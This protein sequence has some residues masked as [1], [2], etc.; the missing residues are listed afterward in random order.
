MKV[1]YKLGFIFVLFIALF[2]SSFAATYNQN[3]DLT[4]DIDSLKG[5]VFNDDIVQTFELEVSNNLNSKQSIQILKPTIEGWDI[6][7]SEENLVLDSNE[8]QIISLKI[9]ANANFDYGKSVVSPDLLKIIQ[10]DNYEGNTNFLFTIL[11][12]NENVSFNYNLVVE[13]KNTAEEYKIEIAT[14]KISPKQP[15]KFS[16]KGENVASAQTIQVVLKYADKEE[17]F[18]DTF[19]A[20]EHYKIY[21]QT[22]ENTIS[23][24]PILVEITIRLKKENGLVWEWI[25]E[26]DII[27][28]EYTQLDIEETSKKGFFKNTYTTT[29]TNLGNIDQEYQ[30]SINVN[31]FNYLFFTSNLEEER[32]DGKAQINIGIEKGETK[33]I[34]F[35]FNYLPIY[36]ILF[37]I[38]ILSIYIYIR[39]NSNPIDVETKIYEIKKV[40][41][42]GVKSMKIRI[43]FENIKEQ[44]IDDLS[45][46]FRMPGYLNVKDNTFLLTEPN[47]VL[48]GKNQY[49]LIWDFKK[50]E[51]DDSRILGFAVINSRGI[52]GDIKIPDLEI[53]VKSK[54]KIRRYTKSFPIIKG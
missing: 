33:D 47:H 50:F 14:Q 51:K 34:V 13:R 39:K 28:S 36:V 25:Q 22:I 2:T 12:K 44:M 43:G 18:E 31:L 49:K 27:V 29:V 16:I 30:K 1:D 3:G 42:E 52:L 19:S 17:V 9:I 32:V 48:K 26:K 46:V 11:G 38:I 54:G 53:E 6:E 20:S 45:I 10:K 35:W 4:V 40:N 24:G 41:H 5:N 15:L 23:P 37:V 7:I 8:K 21:E